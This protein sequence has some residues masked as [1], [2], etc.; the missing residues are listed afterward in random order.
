MAASIEAH[1]TIVEMSDERGGK[2]PPKD[3]VDRA[4]DRRSVLHSCFE[5]D[6]DVGGEKYRLQQA[7]HLI[8][9]VRVKIY[10][11]TTVLEAPRF[12]RDPE[13]PAKV[14]G[15]RDV[16]KAQRR[17]QDQMLSYEVSRAIAHINRVCTFG[18]SLGREAEVIVQ[19]LETLR[20]D[21]TE[22]PAPSP[23]VSPDSAGEGATA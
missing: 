5:W 7:R 14:Q 16:Q 3:V 8:S 12:I 10:T 2:L 11:R 19:L 9:Q 13:L 4:R 22:I 18:L 1:N 21:H 23:V 17:Q 6:N 15:Y 20:R